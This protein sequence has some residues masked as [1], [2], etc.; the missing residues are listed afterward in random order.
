MLYLEDRLLDLGSDSYNTELLDYI[1]E[2]IFVKPVSVNVYS[3]KYMFEY[4]KK[5]F[6][7]VK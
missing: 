2:K 4:F 6:E 1:L 7:A 5:D 3:W